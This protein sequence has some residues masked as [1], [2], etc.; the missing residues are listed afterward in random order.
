[1]KN[2][3]NIKTPAEPQAGSR[4]SEYGLENHGLTNLRK[5]YW[6]LPNEALIEEAI[7]RSEGKIT[8]DGPFAVNTGATY[9]TCGKR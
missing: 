2:I 8:L 9:C 7:F 6:N 1:M 3:L 4:K 5:E